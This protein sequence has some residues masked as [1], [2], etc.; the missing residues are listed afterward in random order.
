[1]KTN[2]NLKVLQ[3]VGVSCLAFSLLAGGFVFY[4][5]T[6]QAEELRQPYQYEI[7]SKSQDP[8]LEPSQPGLLVATIKNIGLEAWPV[9][10]LRL[11][12]IYMDGTAGRPSWFA[13]SAWMEQTSIAPSASTQQTTVRPR[14]TVSFSIPLQAVKRPALYQ[15][16]FRLYLGTLALTGDT[17]GWL[18][19]VGNQ[20]SYQ[21]MAGKQIQIWL[22]DQHIWAIENNVV[23]L[24]TL[25]SSGKS[26]YA[27][28]KGIYKI[29]NHIDTAYS[30]PYKLHMDNWMALSSTTRGFRGY[31]MHALPYW[32]T[33]QTKIADGSI[34]NGRLYKPGKVYEDVY[35]LGKVMSHGCVRLGIKE[36]KMLYDWAPNGTPVVIG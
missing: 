27:T 26:G 10:Q 32:T 20:L 12:G 16:N 35:H 30:S 4:A 29:L 1:M 21:S 14:E 5:K 19:Q 7:V 3:S 15:E 33:R 17:V 23:I 25:V 2:I 31:G 11:S 6:S 22:E 34:V 24:D 18:I 13:T 9:D 28:P 36:S 8:I